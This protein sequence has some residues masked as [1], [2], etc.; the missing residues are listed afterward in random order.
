MRRSKSDDRDFIEIHNTNKTL[1]DP[2]ARAI[3]NLS[4]MATVNGGGSKRPL[5]SPNGARWWPGQTTKVEGGS[6]MVEAWRGKRE[7]LLKCTIRV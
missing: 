2:V 4:L 5:V 6:E 1:S 3:Y 7:I